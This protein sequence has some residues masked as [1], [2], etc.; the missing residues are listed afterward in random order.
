MNYKFSMNHNASGI[1]LHIHICNA[2]GE[3]DTWHTFEMA[4]DELD[5]LRRVLGG[6]MG[7]CDHCVELKLWKKHLEGKVISYDMAQFQK[8][9]DNL[10]EHHMRDAARLVLLASKKRGVSVLI[11]GWINLRRVS[12]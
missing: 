9:L 7:D 1:G 11:T 5:E 6:G 10:R 3:N 12:T 8:Q 2:I 4:S